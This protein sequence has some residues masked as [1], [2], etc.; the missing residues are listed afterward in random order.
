[1][2]NVLRVTGDHYGAIAASQQARELAAALGESALQVQTSHSLGLA[3]YAI[4]DFGRATELLQRSV[5]AA[6]RESGTPSTRLRIVSRAWL[7]QNLSALGTFAEGQRHGEE[8]LRLATLESRGD[9]SIVVHHRLGLLYLAKGDLEHAIRVFEQGLALC[10]ASGERDSLRGIVA[11]LGYA[12]ALQGRLAEG[13]A[14]LEEGISEALRTGALLNHSLRV[15]WLSE[16]CRLAGC[17]EEARQHARQALDLARHHKEHAN[18]AVALHQLG[19]IQAHADP[20]DAAQAEAYY[21]QALALA[22]ELGMRPLQAHCRGGL[23]T[24]YAAR[25]QW[26]QAH[27]ELSAAIDLYRAMEMMFWLPQAEAALARVERRE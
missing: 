27:A 20:P 23:G 1:M 7:A 17:G 19:V 14:L 6:D 5:E 3:Y 15:A 9:A 10:R 13:R 4:G 26:E 16:V 12:D 24:L 2:A 21:Q 18:E 22:N 11:G 8:A 25:G